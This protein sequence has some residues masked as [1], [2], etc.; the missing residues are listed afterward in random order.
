MPET[1]TET[2]LDGL[3]LDPDGPSVVAIGGG[4][5]QAA[6][7]EAVQLY[8]GEV[9]AIVSVADDG[10]SSGRIMEGM[11][12]P[13]PGDV[14]RCL[15]ALTP[16]PALISELFAHRFRGGDVT[17]HS[18]G[19]LM[20]AA[21]TEL[22][23]DF[24]SAVDAAASMLGTIGDVIPAVGAHVGLRAT[25]GGRTIDGQ[26]AISKTKGPVDS[27]ELV[28]PDVTADPRALEAVASADQIV[29]GPGS[30][31]TSV[32]AV[33]LVPGLASA[34]MN[35]RGHRIFVSNLV[36]QDGETLGLDGPGH[37][38]VLSRLGGVEGPGIVVAHDG[39]LDVPAGLEAVEFDDPSVGGW[40]IERA[41]VAVHGARWPEHD[42]MALASVL[43][44]L[45]D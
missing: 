37:L 6:I 3:M 28:P 32:V 14:R 42:P 31:F 23:G 10:G 5:G 13:A 1:Q 45:V 38:D 43:E 39:P 33:L 29:I 9:T 34:V 4:H 27:L 17:D 21:L 7:L 2:S 15:L 12:I 26:A 19:N 24:G 44:K 36:T 25:F 20:L 30:L 18:L 22:Y 8:A 35:A 16:E 41:D 40:L 11:D